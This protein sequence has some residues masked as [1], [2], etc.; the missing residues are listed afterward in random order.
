M[1]GSTRRFGLETLVG[2]DGE[3]HSCK[4]SIDAYLEE[5]SELKVTSEVQ[6]TKPSFE[7]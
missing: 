2:L 7:R 4:V 3:S 5:Y 1:E 6:E